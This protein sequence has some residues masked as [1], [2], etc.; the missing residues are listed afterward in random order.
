MNGRY[1]SGD[2]MRSTGVTRRR[3]RIL[4][5]DDDERLRDVLSLVL[6]D[7]CEV[8]LAASGPEAFEHLERDESCFDVIVCD[9][10]MPQM[11]G[12][13]IHAALSEEDPD[14]AAR[15]VIVTGGAYSNASEEFLRRSGCPQVPKPFTPNELMGA[16]HEILLRRGPASLRQAG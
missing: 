12:A 2:R 1:D 7:D 14:M 16:I 13:Q 8:T 5:I 11:G 3:P 6:A 10:S 4:I 9:L 15:M